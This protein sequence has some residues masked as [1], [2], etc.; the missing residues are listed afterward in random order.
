MSVT[1]DR[2]LLFNMFDDILCVDALIPQAAKLILA[3]NPKNRS[4]LLD[5]DRSDS[6]LESFDFDSV[7]SIPPADYDS[8]ISDDFLD[9]PYVDYGMLLFQKL[10]ALPYYN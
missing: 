9:V 3:Q 10:E 4:D 1:F 2:K 7:P 8:F 5:Q 6:E